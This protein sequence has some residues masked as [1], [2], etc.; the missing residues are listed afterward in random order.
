MAVKEYYLPSVLKLTGIVPEVY[1]SAVRQRMTEHCAVKPGARFQKIKDMAMMV[2][3]AFKPVA[4]TWGCTALPGFLKVAGRALPEPQVE[5][6]KG[7]TKTGKSWR[8]DIDK[9][10]SNPNPT[11]GCIE[12][13]RACKKILVV[14]PE[15]CRAAWGENSRVLRNSLKHF[16]N[17]VDVEFKEH[18]VRAFSKT[19]MVAVT[20]KYGDKPDIYLIWAEAQNDDAYNTIKHECYKLGTPCQIVRPDSFH[21]AKNK[22]VSNNVAA[23]MHTKVGNLVWKKTGCNHPDTMVVGLASSHAGEGSGRGERKSV[24]SLACSYNSTLTGYQTAST[25]MDAGATIARELRHPFMEGVVRYQKENGNKAPKEIVF[26]RE[27]GS[28]GEIPLI[29]SQEVLAVKDALKELKVTA[30][31]TFFLVLRNS[32]LRAVRIEATLPAEAG[33]PQIV[34]V[35]DAPRLGSIVDTDVVNPLGME[36]YL[37]SQEAN[38]GS[39]QMIKYKC[40]AYDGKDIQPDKYQMMANDLACLYFNWQGPIALPAPVMYAQKDAK[41][42][43]TSLVRDGVMP[44]GK[45]HVGIHSL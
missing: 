22:S 30:K 19:D 2:L 44:P 25:L 43:Q 20:A 10:Q 28:E 8:F 18:E 41:M 15:H 40:L 12:A 31:V 26:F 38:I 29:M 45:A 36:F 5:Q 7:F 42:A 39:P 34:K 27:G 1:G 16:A 37:L 17:G 21:G 9:R 33:K 3:K 4:T 23:Q 14:V 11:S 35:R 32:H 24:M 13:K 6:S